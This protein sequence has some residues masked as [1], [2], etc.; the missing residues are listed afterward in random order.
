MTPPNM[1]IISLV[2]RDIQIMIPIIILMKSLLN[3]DIIRWLEL[4]SRTSRFE[5]ANLL[6]HQIWP[7][8]MTIYGQNV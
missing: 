2:M 6:C 7:Q 3:T 1:V 4:T 8:L 5:D